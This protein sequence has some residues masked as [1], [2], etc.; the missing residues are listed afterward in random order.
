MQIKF[1]KLPAQKVVFDD[2]IT[3]IIMFSGGFGSGKTYLLCMK[4]IKL[5]YQNKE[6]SGG[7]MAPSYPDIKRDIVPTFI[8]IL[9]KNKVKYKYHSTDKWFHFPWMNKNSKLYLFSAEKPLVG[10]NLAYAGM[11]EMSLIPKERF[12]ETLFRVRVKRAKAP[13]II[14]VGTPEDRF[15]FLEEFVEQ[16]EN[17]NEKEVGRFKIV[18]GNTKENIH[19]D[20]NY[21]KLLE[22]SLDSQALKVFMEG[23]IVRLGGNY[24]YYAFS[25]GKNIDDSVKFIPGNRVSISMD[26]NI[27]RMTSTFWHIVGQN[28]YAFDELLLLGNSDTRQMCEAIKIRFGIDVDL[29]LDASAKNRSTKGT[30]DLQI[31]QSFGFKNIFFKA[32]NPTFRD[33]QLI[34]NGKL[35]RGE[36]KINPICKSLIKDLK[37][38]RQVKSDYSKEKTDQTLTH[39]SD[40]MDYLLD[41]LFPLDLNRK[42]RTI[43]L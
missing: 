17:E 9:T 32:S 24:F 5:S 6:F 41:Y 34:V 7:V 39:S 19:L 16:Q 12:Y 28:A 43:Q 27:G 3:R 38:V 13:Q 36:V 31:I 20:Q 2:D 15:S 30:S 1:K 23:Q 29:Y 26:F 25:I 21:Q 14:L 42:S 33:R 4:M 18:Y 35:D 22:S 37:S 11:N 8:D 10:P 40:G